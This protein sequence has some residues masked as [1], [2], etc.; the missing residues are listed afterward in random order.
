[1]PLPSEPD[2]TA[3]RTLPF[4]IA[5]GYQA[6]FANKQ[7]KPLISVPRRVIGLRS[8][9]GGAAGGRGSPF[10]DH[11]RAGRKSVHEAARIMATLLDDLLR[12]AARQPLQDALLFRRRKPA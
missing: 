9:V 8:R 10:T 2:R 5:L 12:Q 11:D 1:M 3:D 7:P 4:V 6:R